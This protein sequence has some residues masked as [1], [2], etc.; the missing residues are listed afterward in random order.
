MATVEKT[1]SL[2]RTQREFLDSNALFR[3]FAG[4]IASGKSWVGAYDMIRRAKPDRLYMVVAPT[5]TLMADSSF[6][7]VEKIAR[8]LGLIRHIAKGKPPYLK[9]A[10]GAEILFRSADQPNMLRGP[11]L[12]GV[13]MDEA[14]L[15]EQEG[16]DIMIGRLREGG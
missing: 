10:T 12:S 5:Y 8:E 9:L 13:W 3:G 1:V 2:Y 11:N 14:S 4:G 16:F 6:R 7:S 15:I